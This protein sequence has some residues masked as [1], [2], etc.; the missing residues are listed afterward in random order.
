M[1]EA[2]L[3]QPG[4]FQFI[5]VG[6]IEEFV[7]LA[8]LV[9]CARGLRA[10]TPRDGALLGATVGFGFAALESAGYAF[11]ALFSEQGGLSLGTL[12]QTELVRGL[13]TPFGHGL[14]TAIAGAVLFAA[15]PRG[16]LRITLPAV[17]AY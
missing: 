9:W 13:L 11:N 5:R 16:R 12:V 17:L 3:L 8:A 2:Y 6:F 15:S 4:V 10:H 1:L 14:W 7:K